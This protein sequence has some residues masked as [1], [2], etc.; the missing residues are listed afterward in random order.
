MV[1]TPGSTL[2][3]DDAVEQ[4]RSALGVGCSAAVLVEADTVGFGPADVAREIA[5]WDEWAKTNKVD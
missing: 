1:S 3:P 2:G 5:Y 4:L